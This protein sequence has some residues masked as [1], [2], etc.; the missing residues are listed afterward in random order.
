MMDF[1]NAKMSK[2]FDKRLLNSMVGKQIPV[3]SFEEELKKIFRAKSGRIYG[4]AIFRHG[5]KMQK[6]INIIR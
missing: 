5:S 1:M 4:G 6:I 3:D 2:N